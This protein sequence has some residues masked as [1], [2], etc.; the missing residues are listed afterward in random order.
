MVPVDEDPGRVGAGGVDDPVEQDGD[1]RLPDADDVDAAEHDPQAVLLQRDG[2]GLEPTPPV[3][4]RVVGLA[5]EAHERQVEGRL[6]RESR[7]ADEQVAAGH[8]LSLTSRDPSREPLPGVRRL[9]GGFHDRDGA[10]A[11]V[12]RRAVDRPPTEARVDEELG[13][14]VTGVLGILLGRRRLGPE[15]EP[16]RPLLVSLEQQL[17]LHPVE[18]ERQHAVLTGD[19]QVA[20]VAPAPRL[21]ALAAE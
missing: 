16:F 19:P 4:R 10:D 3:P 5:D 8:R 2:G 12:E 11:E 6:E 17:R 20:G 21:V 15:R 9:P 14:P 18:V 7:R 1:L 13:R